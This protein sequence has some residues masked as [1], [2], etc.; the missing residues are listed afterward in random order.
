MKIFKKLLFNIFG[1]KIE[2]IV[3]KEE[4]LI[5]VINPK[6]VI[7]H[8]TGYHHPK[9]S[10]SHPPSSIYSSFSGCTTLTSI[11]SNWSV[12]GCTSMEEPFDYLEY[13]RKE[14][15]KEFEENPE[16]LNCVLADLREDK[17]KKIRK[18]NYGR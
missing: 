3:E 7:H 4:E 15:K 5:S 8:S 17:I 14:L 10:N 16:L 9:H 1:G 18:K 6:V 12:S 2:P 11:P 13:R